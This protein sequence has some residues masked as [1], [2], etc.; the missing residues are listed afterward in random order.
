VARLRVAWIQGWPDFEWPGYRGGHVYS[1]LIRGSSLTLEPALLLERFPLRH[2]GQQS[3]KAHMFLLNNV[4]L[5]ST[6]FIAPGP[7]LLL[8]WF[9]T[10][11]GGGTLIE[12][13]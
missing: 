3:V 11:R 13:A 2:T 10:P 5:E 12:P 6:F 8:A 7:L 9:A 4:T 1:V